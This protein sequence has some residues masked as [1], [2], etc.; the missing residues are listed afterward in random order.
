MTKELESIHKEDDIHEL[1]LNPGHQR[2]LDPVPW[3]ELYGQRLLGQHPQV[4][5]QLVLAELAVNM[6]SG[7]GRAPLALDC[8]DVMLWVAL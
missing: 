6:E 2:E 3:P 5:L 8:N 1:R 4:L 7:D